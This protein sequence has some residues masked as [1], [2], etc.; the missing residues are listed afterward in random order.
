MTKYSSGEIDTMV[1][2]LKRA[3]IG[4]V[5]EKMGKLAVVAPFHKGDDDTMYWQMSTGEWESLERELLKE[6]S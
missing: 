1:S 3:V 5:F 4:M 6:V 2:R